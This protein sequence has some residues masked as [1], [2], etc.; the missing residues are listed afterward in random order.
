VGFGRAN[1]IGFE[2]V[3]GEAVLF[4]NPDT[5][6]KKGAVADLLDT[7][8]QLPEAGM[9]GPRLI[10][11]SGRLQTNCVQ[12]LPTPLNQALDSEF[13]RRVL[14]DLSIWGTSLAFSSR[15]AVEVEAIS[16]ACILMRSAIFR[17]VGGF[18]PE[19]F[20]YGEDMDLCAKVR[21][22]GWKIVHVPFAEV[23][24]HGGGSSA[25]S[26]DDLSSI[27]MRESVFRFIRK[28]QGR[29]AAFRYRVFIAISAVIRIGVLAAASTLPAVLR[30]GSSRRSLQK[31]VGILR[32]SV[33]AG[34]GSRDLKL[35]HGRDINA[36]CVA[37]PVK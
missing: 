16:G 28:H 35:H 4:L 3:T 17:K 1:N 9:I 7:L 29:F 25:G 30:R 21:A 36:I 20:M 27:V 37:S 32:W 33:T 2:P 14:P 12:A 22:C 6:I 15:T 19:Y 10:D 24:H 34:G 8:E 26:V 18:S 31:W 23:M 11:A 13:M 5:E